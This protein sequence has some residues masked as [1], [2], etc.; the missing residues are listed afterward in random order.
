MVHSAAAEAT[1]AMV[2]SAAAEASSAT[3]PAS[4]RSA[5]F[6]LTFQRRCVLRDRPRRCAQQRQRQTGYRDRGGNQVY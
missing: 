1:T 4:Q 6:R 5:A 3:M 2:H